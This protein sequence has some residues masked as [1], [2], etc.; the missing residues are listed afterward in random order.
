MGIAPNAFSLLT[1]AQM[2]KR[3]SLQE[4]E[5]SLDKRSMAV[6]RIGFRPGKRS[7]DLTEIV[8]IPKLSQIQ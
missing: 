4:N 6:G 2:G 5:K 7:V 1:E 8:E 3:S